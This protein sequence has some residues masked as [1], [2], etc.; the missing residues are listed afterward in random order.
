MTQEFLCLPLFMKLFIGSAIV[1]L[2]FMMVGIVKQSEIQ[3]QN[4]MR[5]CLLKYK[6]H[7]PENSSGN[8]LQSDIEELCKLEYLA[9]PPT[10]LK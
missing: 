4:D 3:Q 10:L 8:I 7:P 5:I 6:F 1:V 9:N 2:I